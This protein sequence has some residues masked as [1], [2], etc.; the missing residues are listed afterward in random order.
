[1]RVGL[2]SLNYGVIYM[3]ISKVLENKHLI[4]VNQCALNV[5]FGL[6]ITVG[7][8]NERMNKRL[9]RVSNSSV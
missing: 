1:M 5:C 3:V 4:Q 7:H 2:C 9:S 8:K 6:G